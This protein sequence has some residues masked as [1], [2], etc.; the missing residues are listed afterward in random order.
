MVNPVHAAPEAFGQAGEAILNVFD[1]L[2][3]L[4]GGTQ[5]DAVKEGVPFAKEHPGA[6]LF[7]VWLILFTL[8]WGAATLI[9]IFK[10]QKN[11]KIIFS[12]ALS[13]ISVFFAGSVI[14]SL[15][16][17]F[18]QF[19]LIVIGAGAI[20][21]L[22]TLWRGF[23]GMSAKAGAGAAKSGAE[24]AKERKALTKSQ[25]DL[26]E[27]EHESN[28]QK[29]TIGD[30]KDALKKLRNA[31]KWSIDINKD[32]ITKLQWILEKLRTVASAGERNTPE[33]KKAIQRILNMVRTTIP[34]RKKEGEILEKLNGLE[35]RIHED[36]SIEF[37]ESN[38]TQTSIENFL[39][40]TS[41]YSGKSEAHRKEMAKRIVQ[42]IGNIIKEK[43]KILVEMDNIRK[44]WSE[45]YA[46]FN[47][48]INDLIKSLEAGRLTEALTA[49]QSALQY[50]K[51]EIEDI[52]L[53]E[54]LE[55]RF[56]GL[57]M[58]GLRDISEEYTLERLMGK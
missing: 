3:G 39:K 22:L 21:L 32:L 51:Q 10:D 34:T 55:Q 19:M 15:F 50:E 5:V 14:A 41:K 27:A 4:A 26:R 33:S 43:N 47:R 1:S 13:W 20:F 40:T 6:V 9:P 36:V 58:R 44:R 23:S 11:A 37:R 16:V 38:V 25:A 31:S 17:S 35:R 18:A 7:A 8:Y 2:G 45:D 52:R 42:N 46:Q 56:E 54:A 24:L 53:I 30:E 28:L 49:C 12:I 57:D 48:L 29:Q